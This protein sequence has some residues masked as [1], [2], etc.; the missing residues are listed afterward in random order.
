MYTPQ[1]CAHIWVKKTSLYLL[2]K[3]LNFFFLVYGASPKRCIISSE[4]CVE[5]LMLKN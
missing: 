4:R 5:L 2:M 3:N 1:D